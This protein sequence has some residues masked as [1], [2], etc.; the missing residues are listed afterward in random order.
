VTDVRTYLKWLTKQVGTQEKPRGSNLQPY[1][2]L[3]GHPNGYAWCASFQVAGAKAT[4]L[5]LPDGA[6]TASCA[7]NEAAYKQAGRLSTTPRVGS[8]FFVYFPSLSRVAHTGV[9][10]K[11]D[12]DRVHTIEGNSN[13]VGAREGYEVCL[14]TRPA[15]RAT[16]TV[17]I[18]SY[19]MPYY[20]ENDMVDLTKDQLREIAHAVWT[21]DEIKN[22]DAPAGSANPTWT[23]RSML[24][25]LENTQD[26]HTQKLEAI[27]AKVAA[28]DPAALKRLT[29]GLAVTVA[30]LGRTAGT[31]G[32]DLGALVQA[33]VPALAPA[34]AAQIAP[35][36]LDGL[37]A[38]LK[39]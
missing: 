21:I 2:A 6:S 1:A 22:L 9:V 23:P 4:E 33:L 37:A 39:S 31:G 13:D 29:D 18:R 7:L 24:S 36:V 8:V 3:A 30:Q 32:I 26:Q 27:E 17:G 25:D 28:L 34:V 16:G 11:V 5:R 19:G 14:R 20:E 15:K 38:R 12:G 35:A 10:W